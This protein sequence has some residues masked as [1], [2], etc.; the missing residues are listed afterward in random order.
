MK[1][2]NRMTISLLPLL[3]AAITAVHADDNTATQT[4]DMTR[5]R[6][7]INMQTPTG[8]FA[9]SQERYQQQNREQHK[10]QQQSRDQHQN[11]MMEGSMH[12]TSVNRS[13]AGT[14]AAG[15]GTNKGR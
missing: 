11:R 12:D 1:T 3:F 5:D 2:I 14:G 15:G 9:Q 13:G 6:E 7:Q 4:R 8:D 10:E